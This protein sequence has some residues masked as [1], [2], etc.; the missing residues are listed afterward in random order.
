MGI[1]AT[2]ATETNNYLNYCEKR[3]RGL[4]VPDILILMENYPVGFHILKMLPFLYK[5]SYSFALLPCRAPWQGNCSV[6]SRDS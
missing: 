1:F 2:K 4:Y 5:P 6:F 3:F